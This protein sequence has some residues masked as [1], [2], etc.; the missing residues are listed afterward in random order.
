M[1]KPLVSVVVPVFNGLPHLKALVSS[2]Q[3]QT[4]SHL[5]VIFT[6][7]GGVDAGIDYLRSIEDPR[8][9]V[10]QMPSGTSASANWTAATSA[11]VGE[12]TKLVCQDDLLYPHAVEVQVLDLLNNP[13]AVMAIARRDIVDARGRILYARRGLTGLPRTGNKESGG[14]TLL[15][16]TQVIR[17]CYLQGTNIIGEPLAVLFRT[18]PLASALPWD[19]TNPLML[20]LS[21][22]ESV[23]PLGDVAARSQSIG[24]F[25]V[26]ASSWSTKIAHMQLAQTRQW[27]DTYARTAVPAI[28]SAER[29]MAAFGR[30]KQTTLRRAAYAVLRARRAFTAEG[31]AR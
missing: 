12:F 18:A 4:Y 13:S 30:H 9:R 17:T 15:P 2:L 26:S 19:D 1:V 5:E 11:A 27:Q 28:T 24:A 22:Y 31:G 8:F 16:G 29:R 10:I 23:A 20:D 14:A 21:M 6:E 25:R 7:G 3:S